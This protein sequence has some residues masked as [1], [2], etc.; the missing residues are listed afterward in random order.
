VPTYEQHRAGRPKLYVEREPVHA[1]ALAALRDLFHAP[2]LLT[3][4]LLDLEEERQRADR[5][6][7]GADAAGLRRDLTRERERLA[8]LF[9]EAADPELDEEEREAVLRAQRDCKRRL[10]R[11]KDQLEVAARPTALLPDLTA[12]APLLD[13]LCDRFD[14]GWAATSGEEKQEL[15]QALIASIP[16]T[17]RS[18]GPRRYQRDVGEPV[19]SDWLSRHLRSGR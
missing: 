11:L 13:F 9:G 6:T 4:A 12:L 3:G 19:Y 18:T 7:F 14:A 15:V 2:D 10:D 1:A 5:G 17:I 16:V 8:T